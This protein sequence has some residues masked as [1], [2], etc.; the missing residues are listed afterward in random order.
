MR[1]TSSNN[2]GRT[3]EIIGHI[4]LSRPPRA[5]ETRAAVEGIL[6]EILA[7]RIVER[8]VSQQ[9]RLAGRG[10][11]EQHD[12]ACKARREEPENACHR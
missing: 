6:H 11:A 2:R 5:A 10:D 1:E 9:G 4:V 8:L 12:A 7:D 3:V